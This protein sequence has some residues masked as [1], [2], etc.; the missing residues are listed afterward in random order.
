MVLLPL[1]CD[2]P[3]S[4]QLFCIGNACKS[5]RHFQHSPPGGAAELFHTPPPQHAHL[6]TFFLN[7]LPSVCYKSCNSSLCVQVVA[8][9]VL[10]CVKLVE[11]CC[12]DPPPLRRRRNKKK[13]KTKKSKHILVESR[14]LSGASWLISLPAPPHHTSCIHSFTRLFDSR[15]S[16]DPSWRFGPESSNLEYL[17]KRCFLRRV[18]RALDRDA[19]EAQTFGLRAELGARS[20]FLVL[21][22]SSSFTHRRKH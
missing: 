15:P 13:T 20:A 4:C 8:F 17:E 14:F 16:G 11:V 9:F 12:L 6:V 22:A 5:G 7:C 2:P 1:T 19:D 21:A 3:P 10:K 18:C